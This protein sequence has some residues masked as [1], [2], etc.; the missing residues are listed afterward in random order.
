MPYFWRGQ[1]IKY[2]YIDRIANDGLAILY[3]EAEMWV[4]KSEQQGLRANTASDIDNQRA[5]GELSPTV[6]CKFNVSTLDRD[7]EKSHSRIEPARM[8]SGDDM[9]L[10]PFM[11]APNRERRNLLSGASNQVH[12]S[13]STLYTLLKAVL[14]DS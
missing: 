2:T 10:K 8:A 4:M 5:L 11:P 7:V 3:N 1:R 9:F 6:P 12:I 13:S 14:F